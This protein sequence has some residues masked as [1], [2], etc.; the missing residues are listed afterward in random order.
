MILESEKVS[1]EFAW[2]DRIRESKKL[3]EETGHN[4]SQRCLS[5]KKASIPII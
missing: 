1:S 4:V 3:R 5:T 2:K